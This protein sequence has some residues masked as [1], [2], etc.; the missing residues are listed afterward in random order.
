MKRWFMN[1]WA[2]ILMV[3][4]IIL[5]VVSFAFGVS[6]IAQYGAEPTTNEASLPSYFW[7]TIGIFVLGAILAIIGYCKR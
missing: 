2:V 4:G 7:G 5:A 6:A 1:Y 3:M